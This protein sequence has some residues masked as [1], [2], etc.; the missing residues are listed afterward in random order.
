MFGKKKEAGVIL[1][2]EGMMCQHCEARVKKTVEAI[3]GV[4]E[5]VPNHKKNTVTV[6]GTCDIQAVKEAIAKEGYIVK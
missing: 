4:T 6:F 3:E 5:A 2:V 1:S